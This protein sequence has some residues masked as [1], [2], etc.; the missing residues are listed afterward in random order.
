[1]YKYLH[2]WKHN[3]VLLMVLNLITV[4]AEKVKIVTA[5]FLSK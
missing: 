1:M 5:S 4:F 3:Q 2:G